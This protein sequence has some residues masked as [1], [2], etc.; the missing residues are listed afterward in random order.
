MSEY[1]KTIEKQNMNNVF[2]E[3]YLYLMCKLCNQYKCT[4]K[5]NTSFFLITALPIWSKAYT[6][7]DSVLYLSGVKHR[8]C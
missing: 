8:R 4:S 5:H 6:L 1:C 7:L 2:I 3:C